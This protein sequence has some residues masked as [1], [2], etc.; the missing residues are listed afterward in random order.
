MLDAAPVI[1]NII[2]ESGRIRYANRAAVRVR[3]SRRVRYNRGTDGQATRPLQELDVPPSKARIAC[4]ERCPQSRVWQE[5]RRALMHSYGYEEH[6]LRGDLSI[7]PHVDGIKEQRSISRS[8][9]A[10]PVAKGSFAVGGARC[11][12]PQPL[13]PRGRHDRRGRLGTQEHGRGEALRRSE[14][15]QRAIISASPLGII[16]L[17]P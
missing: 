6:P 12:C 5:G 9:H 1:I 3:H 10:S 15:F 16:T 8:F 4:S 14:E 2:D 7:Q 11:R 17:D 13:P